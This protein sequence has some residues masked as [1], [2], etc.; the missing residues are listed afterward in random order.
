MEGRILGFIVVCMIG[1]AFLC[2]A[3]Y[4]WFS[5]KPRIST[6]AKGSSAS[7]VGWDPSSGFSPSQE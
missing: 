6:A 2:W 3:V 1:V 5:K 4:A 7:V